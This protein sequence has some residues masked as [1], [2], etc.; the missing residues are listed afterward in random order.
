MAVIE[1]RRA[2]RFLPGILISFPR[3]SNVLFRNRETR[4][5]GRMKFRTIQGQFH[6]EAASIER[7][8]SRLP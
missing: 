4:Q 2:S 1:S 5:P 7:A 6:L 3:L 8:R